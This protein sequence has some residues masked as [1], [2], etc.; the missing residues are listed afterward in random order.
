MVEVINKNNKGFTLVELLAVIAIIGI[1]SVVAIGVYRGVSN[2]SKQKAYEAKIEQINNAASKW[3]RENNIDKATVISVNK[4]VVEGYLTADEVSADGLAKIIN[5]TDNKNMIC[6]TVKISYKKGEIVVNYDEKTKNCN[7]A[8]QVL[9]DKKIKV[10]A[11]EKKVNTSPKLNSN[12]QISW[13]NQPLSLIVFSDDYKNKTISITYDFEGN[14]IEKQV[15]NHSYYEDEEDK[16]HYILNPDKYYNVFNVDADVIYNGE[17]TITYN[18]NDGTSKSKVVNVRIDKEEATASVIADAEWVTNKQKVIVKADDGNGSG[19]RRVYIGV[20]SSYDSPGVEP[21]ELC[22]KDGKNC[23]YEQEFKTPTVGEFNIWT[24]DMV[25]NISTNPKNK[26]MINNVDDAV[27]LCSIEFEGT[28][29]NGDWY[30]SEVVPKVKTNVAGVSGV[31]YGIKK[32]SAKDYSNYVGYGNIGSVFLSKQGDTKDQVYTCAVKSLAGKDSSN[33][34]NVKVDTTKP[35]VTEV[36]VSSQNSG[37][38]TNNVYV[39]VKAND[40]ISGLDQLCVQTSNNVGLC[41]WQDFIETV[42]RNTGISYENGGD[43][44]FYVWVKDKAGLISNVKES[45]NYKVYK[46]CSVNSNIIDNGGSTCGNDY[47]ACT[48]ICGGK[49]YAT[50]YQGKKDKYT[51]TACA[52]LTESSSNSC[53]RDCGGFTYV[54]GTTCSNVCGG[55]YNRLAYST[56]DSSVRCETKDLTSGG[57]ACGGITYVDGGTCSNAC[58]GTYNRLAY[59]TIDSS[60]RCESSDVTTGGAACGGFNKVCTKKWSKCTLKK[61]ATVKTKVRTTTCKYPSNDGTVKA[62]YDK[63]VTK[64]TITCKKPCSDSDASGCEKLYICNDTVWLHKANSYNLDIYND[65]YLEYGT[66][67]KYLEKADNSMLKVYY[68]TG[69]DEEPNNIWYVRDT[70]LAPEGKSCGEDVCPTMRD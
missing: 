23:K 58:G 54:D 26:I 39:K 20:G 10:F 50:K 6:N 56:I 68:D 65:I 25:G 36:S 4:L 5:P 13:T 51:G 12:N 41:Q 33:T 70:C 2:N 48:N 55:T 66:E 32:G 47:G 31:Y 45:G 28:K 15:T 29:G 21:V 1:L 63:K 38:N 30:T 69:D 62:C 22:D 46:S 52:T 19:A 24:E 27:P 16:L 7:L 61:G 8:E 60:V 17:V 34:V 14:S 3:A 57:A 67:I 59:S 53:S 49:Q 44:K 64:K 35:V 37:Y 11:K 18:L 43:V 9:D 42:T 40:Q